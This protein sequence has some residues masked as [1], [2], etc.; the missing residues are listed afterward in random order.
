M[1]VVANWALQL[2]SP[3]PEPARSRHLAR[4][5]GLLSVATMLAY[6]TW[7]IGTTLP[8]GEFN[9][10]LAWFLI[11][12][13]VLSLLAVASKTFT[14]W[15][16]DAPAPPPVTEAPPGMRLVL[17]IPTYNEPRDVIGPTVATA[18]ALQPAHETWVLDDGDRPWVAEMS[19][20]LGARYVQRPTHDHAK[21]GNL[22]HALAILIEEDEAGVGGADIIGVLDCDHV[23]LPAFFLATLGW[24]D[25]PE[26]AL[27]QAPQFLYNKG[28]FDDDGVSGEQGLYFNVMMPA[29]QHAGVGPSWC[30]STSLVRV[31]ALRQIGGVATET[32]TE[33]MHT[34]LKLIKAGWKTA[35]QHQTLA[36]GLGPGTAAQYLLQRRRWGQGSMQVFRQEHLLSAKRWLS[37]RNYYEFTINSLWWLEGLGLLV[38]LCVPIFILF[39]AARTSTARPQTYIGVFVV[40]LLV[41]LWGAKRLLRGQI[42]WPTA[43]ALRVFRI[44]IGLSCAWMLLFNRELAFDVTP[45]GGSEDRDRGTA[46]RLLSAIATI[47]AGVIVYATLGVL[48]DVPWRTNPAS[49]VASG[50]WLVVA[51]FGLY[52]ALRRIRARRYANTRRDAPRMPFAADVLMDGVPG[53]LVDVSV[54]GAAVMPGPGRDNPT[55][56]VDLELPGGSPVR[57]EVVTSP[58]RDSHL[59]AL[60][61]HDD[62]WESRRALSLWLFHTP[63]DIIPGL[64]SG[65]PLAAVTLVATSASLTMG[66]PG[67]R[68]YA[69]A[70]HDPDSGHRV[71]SGATDAR[72][73]RAATSELPRP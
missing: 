17:L 52:C 73:A 40:M 9:R 50:V 58:R 72:L 68:R 19:A 27:V 34:T 43:F 35:Y 15:N 30:G 69:P 66:D 2:G 60:R 59:V 25:D 23:P 33:D 67:R 21:A 12:F 5:G 56:I 29:R 11:S 70:G 37:W 42:R 53:R 7:R 61:I 48:H 71:H 1:P 62:D 47:I 6:L 13:D 55:G 4:A 26:I 51:E 16:I 45:K 8:S 49:T 38:A 22:N 14:L 3:R 39:S 18:C 20:A 63:S 54:G 24:F 46:P 28:A 36:V 31:A 57:M 32:V 41:R 65:V 64:P 10:I 44:P